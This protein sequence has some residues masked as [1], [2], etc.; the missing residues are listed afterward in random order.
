MSLRAPPTHGIFSIGLTKRK[1]VRRKQ[2]LT[3]TTF[4]KYVDVVGSNATR[5]LVLDWWRH[6]DLAL[7]DCFQSLG[8]K[9]PL[10][11]L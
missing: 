10:R 7:G 1:G 5:A 11:T 2:N 4:T 3:F 9:G 8:E 6:L